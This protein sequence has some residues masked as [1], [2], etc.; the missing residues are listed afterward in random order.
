MAKIRA[1]VTEGSRENGYKRVQV[2]FGTNYFLDIVDNNGS[3][4][5][6]L[7]AHDTGFKA[8][9]SEAKGEL[10]KF[11]SEVLER[12]PESAMEQE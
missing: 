7:G 6:L 8:D 10:H 4:Q 12:H 2:W 11:I 9:A 1:V 5:F 3:V